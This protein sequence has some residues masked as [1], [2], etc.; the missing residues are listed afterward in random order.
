MR[1][2]FLKAGRIF[3]I[4]ILGL[5]I[6]YFLGKAFIL[7]RIKQKIEKVFFEKTN[8][9][10]KI[11]D[12]D[13]SLLRQTVFVQAI[14]F[15]DSQNT[16]LYI[17]KVSL[18]L[19]ANPFKS[20]TVPFSL[21]LFFEDKGEVFMTGNI[22]ILKKKLARVGNI[23]LT[24]D[25]FS[26][27]ILKGFFKKYFLFIPKQGLAYLN[28]KGSIQGTQ[29]DSN[30]HLKLSEFEFETTESL[31]SHVLGISRDTLVS[32]LKDSKGNI[33]LDFSLNGNWE[34][35]EFN[36]QDAIA[37]AFSRAFTKAML[38]KGSLS[39]K[40]QKEVEKLPQDLLKVLPLP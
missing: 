13:F 6:V 19:K 7:E 24:V 1:R 8:L 29:F 37:E 10:L 34:K 36:W 23:I 26:L 11:A 15:K 18:K 16:L 25:H 5:F 30:H 32:F 14:A 2:L 12:L 9:T 4:I 20:S 21:S 33:E 27:P 28:S 39:K 35:K 38:S 22:F 40:I 31:E 17:H 3:L